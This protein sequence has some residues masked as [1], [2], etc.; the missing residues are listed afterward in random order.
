MGFLYGPMDTVKTLIVATTA[1]RLCPQEFHKTARVYEKKEAL[2]PG[3]QLFHAPKFNLVQL[4]M[5]VSQV[6]FISSFRP[7]FQVP[8]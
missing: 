1:H 2:C 8:C 3:R 6:R 4:K 7:D 5:M